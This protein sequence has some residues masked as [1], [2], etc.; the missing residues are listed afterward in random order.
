MELTERQTKVLNLVKVAH[1]D[2]KRKYTNMD[3]WTHC[4]AVADMVNIYVPHPLAIEIALCH[5][6]FEDTEFDFESLL[7]F[8]IE[9]GYDRNDAR[10]ICDHVDDL[11]DRFTKN[12]Y[13][14][15][16]RERR[17][18]FE[19]RRLGVIYPLAQSIKYADLIDNTS[20]IVDFDLNFSEIYLKEKQQILDEMKGGSPKLRELCL[21]TYYNAMYK[22]DFGK[23]LST[24]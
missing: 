17:K 24:V 16:N 11:T 21:K 15:M 19:A 14:N 9:V 5:D 6:L 13:P 1:G 2:Q 10:F 22:L 12:E 20:T 8:L 7:T 23:K 3:Y 4:Y 18:M